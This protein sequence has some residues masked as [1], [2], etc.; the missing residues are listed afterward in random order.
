MAPSA[1]HL[2]Q[3]N[4]DPDLREALILAVDVSANTPLALASSLARPALRI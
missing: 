1:S 4:L 2:A 3:A